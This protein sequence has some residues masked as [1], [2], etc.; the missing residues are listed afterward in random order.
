MIKNYLLVSIRNLTKHKFYSLINILGLSIGL[1]CFILISLFVIDELSYDSFQTDADRIHRMDFA[2]SVNG[3]EFITTLAGA[4]TAAAMINDFPEV[5]D[6][7]RFRGMGDR[8]IKR[9]DKNINV[10]EKKLSWS[11]K[12]FFSFWDIELLYGDPITCLERPGTVV[13]SESKAKAFFGEEDPMGQTLVIDDSDDLEITGVYKDMPENMHFHYDILLS[14]EGREE[15]KQKIWMS[16]NFN[17]YLKLAPTANPDSL[18]AKFPSLVEK[19]IGPEI[20][21]FLG[22]SME[23]FANAGNYGGFTLFPMRDIHL[24]SD[25]MGELE[26]NGSIQYVYIFSAI[27]LFILILACINFMNLSTARSANRAKEVGVRK[28]MG[29]YKQHLVYQFL[30]E[31][32]LITLIS[33]LIAVMISNIA[34]PYFNEIANKSIEISGLFSTSFVA[35]LFGIMVIVGLLAGSYPAFYLAKFKP[36][37]V[38]K[39][40]LNLGLKSGGIRSTLVVLQFSVSIMMMVGTAIVFDQLNYVQ[41]KKLGYDKDQVVM[42]E[43]AWLLKKNLD[44][45]KTEVLRDPKILNGT[46]ASFLPVGTTNNNNLWFKGK[47]AGQGDNYVMHNYRVDH[48]YI[49]TLGMK[50]V[51]GRGFSKDFPTDSVG[52]LI[53]EAAARQIGYANPIGEFIATYGGSQQAPVSAPF[54]I[55]GVVKDFHYST[56]R[57][58]ID[59]LIFSLDKRAGFISFKI[60]SDNIS[61]TIESI[62]SQWNELAPGQPFQ[63]SFLNDRFNKMYDAEQRIGN[64]FSIFAFLAIFI[65]CLGLYGLAAFTAEQKTKEIG[66]RKVLGASIAQIITLLGKEFI[67][68]LA[69]SFIIGS[70]VSYF[71]MREWLNEFVYRVDINNPTSFIIAGLVTLV[72]SWIT[73]SSQSLKAART[74]PVNSLKDE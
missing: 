37:E 16:F 33:I 22:Q 42:I 34:L 30:S 45:F 71:V 63:Y 68:L 55:V 4:P 3:K 12:N 43:D 13:I 59:P 8:L 17:T 18:E 53:N 1:T 46:V 48:D 10:K 23:E 74:N 50:I 5:E 54:K 56:M 11:D 60:Q 72:I 52:V 2:G 47:T 25:K 69:I 6:A 35:I 64:I 29:A 9:K 49:K 26:P 28:V 21:Q 41:N 39:G 36:V 58:N 70:V 27:A 57:D 73:M 15:S 67:K 7:F 38:L 24:R 20:E 66:I 44:A 32:F 19:Y 65:A 14:M 51:Q 31:A 40:K 61:S 62:K